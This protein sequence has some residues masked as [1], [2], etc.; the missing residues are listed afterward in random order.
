MALGF[1]MENWGCYSGLN[2]AISH[3]SD[4]SLIRKIYKITF[5]KCSTDDFCIFFPLWLL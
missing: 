1:S 3:A 2:L 5:V 4:G